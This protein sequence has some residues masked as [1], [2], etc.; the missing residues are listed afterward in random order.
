VFS[1]L[2]AIISPGAVI[3]L[4]PDTQAALVTGLNSIQVRDSTDLSNDLK[5][6]LDVFI[7]ANASAIISS[8]IIITDSASLTLT[9]GN[10]DI[11][12][13]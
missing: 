8:A 6:V 2:N 5:D 12:L 3:M 10:S 4:T 1:N 7:I 9:S 13:S 11:S